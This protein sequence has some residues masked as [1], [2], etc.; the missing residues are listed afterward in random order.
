M[1]LPLRTS[2]SRELRDNLV[3][4]VLELVGQELQEV[5]ALLFSAT[6]SD[7]PFIREA[8]QDLFGRGGKRMR[9]ALLLLASRSLGCNGSEPVTYAAVIELIHTATLVHDDIL[10]HA[11]LRR[12]RPTVHAAHGPN[13]AVLLGDWLFTKAMKMA[14][15]CG[16]LEALD[17]L[18]DATLAMTEGELLAL[19]RLGDPNLSVEE[20]FAVIEHKTARLFAAA[21][22]LPALLL[23]EASPWFSALYNYGRAL[24][25]CF[26]LTDDLL[27]FTAREE[28]LGKPVLSDL[29]EGKLTLPLLLALPRLDPSDRRQI[30]LALSQRSFENLMAPEKILELV[31]R[32]GTLAEVESFAKSFARDAQRAL[33]VLPSGPAREVLELAPDYVVYRRS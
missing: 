14:I 7:V 28:E 8:G 13:R 11:L 18:A 23:E 12:G 30:E 2:P 31:D 32:A 33:G 6:E 10:D 22:A 16:K 3:Q 24:G 5:E 9:P 26:Q 29:R 20:Y 17:L 21:C 27:D 4:R 15:G 25:L 1:T 19:A